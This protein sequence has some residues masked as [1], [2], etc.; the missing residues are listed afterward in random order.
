MSRKVNST[1]SSDQVKKAFKIFEGINPPGHVR[2]DALIRALCTYG[3]EV[4]SEEQAAELIHQM[5][6]DAGGLIN[7][8]EYVEMMMSSTTIK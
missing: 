2:A 1:Y 4:L 3:K 8:S 7:Y 5:D 6:I